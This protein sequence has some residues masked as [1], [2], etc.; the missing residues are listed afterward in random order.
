M[1]KL[2][3][4]VAIEKGMR[5]EIYERVTKVYHALAKPDLLSGFSKTYQPR[6]E[7][8]DSLPPESKKVQLTVPD[9]L[10]EIARELTRLMDIT[11]V[12]DIANT[13]ANADVVVDGVTLVKDAPVPYLLFLEKQLQDIHTVISKLPVLDPSKDWRE[14][15][16]S[17]QF[18]TE[19]VLTVRTKKVM[20]NHV[21]AEATEK[22]PAQVEV[23]NED[24]PVGDWSLVNFSGCVP[25]TRVRTL[26][27]RVEK[28]MAVVKMAREDANSHEVF[29]AKCGENVFNY[30]FA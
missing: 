27:N 14:S 15:S 23:Y 17:S 28:L 4:V 7:D 18:Q 16:A 19:P 30:L 13:T 5:K 3:Q 24:I 21:K 1:A 26:A 22:H 9:A 8:G 25:E 20:R 2:C 6:Q 11:L 10:A 12:K 29:D